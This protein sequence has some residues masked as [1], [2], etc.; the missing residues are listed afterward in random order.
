MNGRK[1]DYEDVLDP[2]TL[3]NGWF[4]IHFPSLQLIASQHLMPQEIQKVK[5]TIKR[6]KLNDATCIKGRMNWLRPYL[7]GQ[8]D[9]AFLE[10]KAPFLALELQRQQL[11]DRSLPIWADFIKRPKN[12]A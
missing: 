2:F 1:G 12:K 3:Q 9:L 5:Q 10:E 11:A 6:L 8:Y 7:L 4:Q